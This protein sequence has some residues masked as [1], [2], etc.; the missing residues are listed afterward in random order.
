VIGGSALLILNGR[1]AGR[2]HYGHADRSAGRRVDDRTIF[3][4]ASVTKTLTGIAVLQ[5][6]DRGLLTLD[7]H[8]TSW[9]P[10]L[11]KIHA[12]EGEIDRITI[13]MLLS[14]PPAFR[15]PPGPGPVANPGSRSSPRAGTSSS[16]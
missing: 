11:R 3:H 16:R 2:H 14:T 8:V 5:L 7:D 4:W 6:R 10:E 15:P 1:P 13:R 12:A 9:I